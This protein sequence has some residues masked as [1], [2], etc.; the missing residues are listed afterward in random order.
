LSKIARQV[1]N[2]PAKY[3]LI[4]KTNNLVNPSLIHVGQVLVIPPLA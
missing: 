1:Y 3:P 2:D 4:Q